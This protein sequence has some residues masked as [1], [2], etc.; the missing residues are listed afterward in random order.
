MVRAFVLLP[1]WNNAAYVSPPPVGCNGTTWRNMFSYIF[2]GVIIRKKSVVGRKKQRDP[3]NW[4]QIRKSFAL[5]GIF[6]MEFWNKAKHIG[7]HAE[8][9][10]RFHHPEKK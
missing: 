6:R 5:L 10:N 4:G 7:I 9:L 2:W 1:R 8:N 3:L